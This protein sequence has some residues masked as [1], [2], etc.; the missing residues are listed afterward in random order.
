[1]S[2]SQ[3]SSSSSGSFEDS[4][5][6]SS[7][8]SEAPL[9]R[10][11]RDPSSPRASRSKWVPSATSNE[12]STGF[13]WA[14]TGSA[15][16]RVT[17]A[18][19]SQAT[20]P[21]ERVLENPEGR[22]VCPI[23]H[24]KPNHSLRRHALT[25]LPWFGDVVKV[26]WECGA[27]YHQHGRLRD[28]LQ[29]V[30]PNGGFE[31]QVNRWVPTIMYLL[32]SFII[33]LGLTGEDAL[34]QYV[35][36]HQLHPDPVEP[37][38]QDTQMMEL[39]DQW[40][41]TPRRQYCYCPPNCVAALLHWKPL[42]LL[43]RSLPARMQE[44]LHSLPFSQVV[45]GFSTLLKSPVVPAP[46][47]SLM[48]RPAIPSLLDLPM[49]LPRHG[50]SE[51]Q[52]PRPRPSST[53]CPCPSPSGSSED[54]R[55]CPRPSSTACP[56]PSPSGSS[57]DQRPS[58]R[59]PSMTFPRP[60][61]PGPSEDDPSPTT[62]AASRTDPMPQPAVSVSTSDIWSVLDDSSPTV[63]AKPEPR[64]P[65]DPRLPSHVPPAVPAPCLLSVVDAHFHPDK[66]L[67]KTPR[68]TLQ[69]AIN[70]TPCGTQ[71]RLQRAFPC[72]AFPESWPNFAAL[73]LPAQVDRIALG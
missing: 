14:S 35:T 42:V 36:T 21:P 34:V 48:S 27:R 16:N 41:G 50:S 49:H 38:A 43:L 71:Y 6:C 63:L 73:T 15:Y 33:G 64:P 23:C 5:L 25:H 18:G 59:P 66:L 45:S 51:D 69:Q 68:K 39:F 57:E 32:S 26:C 24:Q 12:S 72:Y 13:T 44:T 58:P 17:P 37:S 20:A 1:M 28:H 31:E 11:K 56:C 55:P 70:F 61:L 54:Q 46:V 47:P 22:R 53:A 4:S 8:P 3:R 9:H 29:R 10:G 19:A 40:S 52:R 2:A 62:S 7:M 67:G 65:E 30:H 60:L